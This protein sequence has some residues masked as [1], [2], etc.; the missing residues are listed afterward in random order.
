MLK[1]LGAKARHKKVEQI[2]LE[3]SEKNTA[4]L[5]LYEKSGFREIARRR[6][7]YK[8]GSD[9]VVMKMEENNG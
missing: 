4:A 6:K 8:D 7:Y 5:A 1:K 3:V 2:H 9:A